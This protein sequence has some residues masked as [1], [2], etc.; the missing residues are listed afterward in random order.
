MSASY[1]TIK[2][3]LLTGSNAFSRW[4]SYVGLGIGVLLLLCSLQMFVN[5]QQLLGKNSIRK[6]GFDFISLSKLVTND[7]MGKDN[8]F[9]ANDIAELKAQPFIE[10]AAPLIPNEFDV[11]ANGGNTIPF[12]S[13]I[14]IEALDNNFIDTVPPNFTWAEGQE[15]VPVIFSSDFLEMYN[16]IGP[17][18]GLPQL[19]QA[20]GSTLIIYLRCEGQLDTVVF[21]A[22]IVAY[23]DRVN[24]VLV[25]KNF[26]E[27]ANKTIEGVDSVKS[28][29]IFIKTRDVNN[30]DLLKFMDQKHYRLNKE[31][32]ILGRSKQKLQGVISGL[33]VFGI[34]VI[35]LALMLF[36]FYL[37]LL[38]ARSKDNLQLLL[39]IGYSPA[40]LSRNLARQFVPVYVFTILTALLLTQLMQWSFHHFAMYDR[41]ELS[42]FV[43]W[44][45]ALAAVLL[46]A[47]SIF[48]NYKM[49]KKLLYR[50]F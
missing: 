4:F 35:I 17:N 11:I 12:S 20:T 32:T 6:D 41:P 33:G 48:A 22:N 49:I 45:V 46:I 15:I 2:P 37:Q 39:T 23:S 43:H 30:S 9:D 10:D 5:I 8:R 29:R 50:M 42:S 26:L 25:P 13:D 38:I 36:S 3:L 24:S 27:W 21:R 40:W 19:S 18:L 7:N 14:F 34:L 44:S 1:K 16:I 47:M 28:S 31:K